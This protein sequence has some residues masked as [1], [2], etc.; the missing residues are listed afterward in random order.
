MN[1]VDLAI[2]AILLVSLL[3]GLFRGFVREVLSLA[4]WLVALWV[5]YQNATFAADYLAPYIAQPSLRVT[6]AFV[7]VFIAVLIVASLLGHLLCNLLAFAGI[8]GI[9]RSLGLAFGFARGLGVVAILLLLAV[10]LE[11]TAQPWWQGSALAGYFAPLTEWLRALMPSDLAIY[12]QPT[13]TI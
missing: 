1:A 8:G 4:A 6:A 11:L 2:V 10:F 9:D 7:I 13:A 5:A 12:L 3:V